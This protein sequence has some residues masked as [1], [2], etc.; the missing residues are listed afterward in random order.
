MMKRILL[1]LLSSLSVASGHAASMYVRTTSPTLGEIFFSDLVSTTTDPSVPFKVQVSLACFATNLRFVSNPVT[2]TAAIKMTIG[3]G[4]DSDP[5]TKAGLGDLQIIF[6]GWLVVKRD[7]L[8][9]VLNRD[10]VVS[11]MAAPAGS[12]AIG[13]QNTI[14]FDPPASFNLGFTPTGAYARID[15]ISALKYVHFEQNLL[16]KGNCWG[17]RK[18]ITK[19][20]FMEPHM[21]YLLPS[22]MAGPPPPPP[23]PPGPPPSPITNIVTPDVPTDI[24]WGEPGCG[25]GSWDPNYGIPMSRPSYTA[26]EVDAFR[27]KYSRY[28]GKDGEL[29]A[30]WQAAWSSDFK[31]L[32]IQV[33]VPGE[34]GFCGAM[35][36]PLMLFFDDSI[37]RFSSRAPFHLEGRQ[38]SVFWP[39]PEAHGYFLALDVNN[40]GQ[41]DDG[42]E[43]FGADRQFS[44][45]FE[46]LRPYDVDGNGK[47][48]ARDPIFHRLRLWKDSTGKGQTLDRDVRTLQ[49]MGVTE[50]NLNYD[51]KT[52][53]SV[54]DR[55]ELREKSNFTFVHGKSKKQ[56]RIVDVWFSGN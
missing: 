33:A 21:R 41:F 17:T 39:E 50:I 8:T 2:P 18:N 38:S 23:P 25:M 15:A 36:S 46:K 29:S 9:P 43:L 26:A 11:L 55:A 47:I 20:K 27:D 16:G 32:S 34:Y 56:G 37:P 19:H 30:Q 1:I 14:T 44:N 53:I 7:P 13:I 51:L 4:P 6:P 49:Q 45:G 52:P 40:N 31:I 48:D 24:G 10:E 3:I 12:A 42:T 5:V 35:Y 22:S 54:G 28:M